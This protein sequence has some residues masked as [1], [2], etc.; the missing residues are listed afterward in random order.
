MKLASLIPPPG[1]NKYELC[2]IAAR[3]ARRMNDWA[4]QTGQTQ[5][6]SGAKPTVVSLDHTIRHEVPFFYEEPLAQ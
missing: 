2:I 4:R 6:P 3:E 5:A 1:T